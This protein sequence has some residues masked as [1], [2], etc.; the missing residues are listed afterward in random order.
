MSV[1]VHHTLL[2]AC[3][4]AGWSIASFL[5]SRR[6]GAMLIGGGIALTTATG[7]GALMTNYAYRETQWV[8][9]RSALRAS[10]SAAGPLLA[11]AGGAADQAIRERVSEFLQ[12]SLSGLTITSDDVIVEYD[13]ATRT[14]T[15][16]IRG[17]YV[18]RNIWPIGEDDARDRESGEAV[19]ETVAV[20]LDVDRY[21]VGIA[22]DVS[23]SMAFQMPDG[24][25]GRVVKIDALKNALSAVVATMGDIVAN[26]P[27]SMMA[28]IVPYGTAVNV[29]D[30]CNPDPGTEVCRAGRSAGKERYLR[31]LA[32]PHDTV[33]ETL[34]AAR[35][36]G[37]QWVDAYHHYG[38]SENLGPLAEQ[39]LP[40]D[41]LD[42]RDWNLR[43]TKVDIDVRAQVP[44]L[45]TG[46]AS[47]LGY[48][49]VN[50][51]DFWNG[52]LMAR[53]GSYWDAG[54]RDPGWAADN[55]DNWPATS[56]VAKWSDGSAALPDSPLHL[57]DEPPDATDPRTLFTAYSWPDA[58][59]GGTA[60]HRLQSVMMDLTG[61]VADG[62]FFTSINN[63]RN[64]LGQ[65]DN[66]WSIREDFGGADQC[67]KTPITPLTDDLDE[68]RTTIHRLQTVLQHGHSRGGVSSAGGTYLNLGV[69]WALRTISPLWRDV[70]GVTDVSTAPR[71]GIPCAP[72]ESS[73]DCD[74]QLNKSIL[75]VSDGDSYPGR[76]GERL[77]EAVDD[78]R[79]PYFV[80]RP[81]GSMCR[82][83]A[84][85]VA[86]PNYTA[87]AQETTESGFNGHFGAYV[88]SNGRFDAAGADALADSFHRFLDDDFDSSRP[89]DPDP[90]SSRRSARAAALVGL[91]PW[92]LFRGVGSSV[93]LDALMDPV[94]QFGFDGRPVQIAHY[95]RRSTIFGP[96]GRVD[97]SVRVGE[98]SGIPQTL[99]PPVA[100]VSPMNGGH[101]QESDSDTERALSS[102]LDRWFHDACR[103]A[104]QRRVRINAVYIGDNS[105]QP[106][107]DNLKQCVALAGGDPDRDVYVTPTADD[108]RETFV[109][110]FTIQRNLRFLD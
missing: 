7:A 28:S 56:S 14:T 42:N 95:C 26:D 66:D 109:D 20:K 25:G 106:P 19:A 61:E 48:W 32:G 2:R 100:G 43:R 35:T 30:T 79:N 27:G 54:A 107:I 37:A 70:W 89:D 50:D 65:G 6:G 98:S 3:R 44:S 82:A 93:G 97:D 15:I 4:R 55:A 60:D 88:D 110:I 75:I 38:A 34:S 17:T 29:A 80:S 21:E 90:N 63:L 36:R 59:I 108:L 58:R 33:T 83:A 99:L 76:V 57:S 5:L 78:G 69:V 22:L 104:G 71:P 18:F 64:N 96:Y 91:T 67:P 73:P 49:Q 102:V 9:L 105:Y 13:T 51:E 39:S 8:E 84:A 87:A 81:L 52:C 45:D 86:L 101:Q 77:V 92:Q 1:R 74:N 62:N 31:M 24:Q 23:S 46:A 72:D 41:L 12:G 53:W 10:V 16:G 68:L 11:S 85:G 40:R 94:N 103:L 47:G